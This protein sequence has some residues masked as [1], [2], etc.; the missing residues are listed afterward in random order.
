MDLSTVKSRIRSLVDDPD[1]SYATDAFLLPL[2]NQKY[3][4][5]YNRMLSTGAEFERRVIELFNVPAQTTNLSSYALTGQPLELMVQPLQ[6]EW[7]QAGLAPTN[8]RAASL[9]DKVED[10]IPGQLVDDWEWRAGVIYFTPSTLALDI[11]I[12]GDFLFAA[13]NTDTDVVA[14]S[15]NFGHA[16]AYGTAALVG[17]VRGNQAWAQAYTL[18][19]DNALDDIMQYLTRKDQAKIRRVGRMSGRRLPQLPKSP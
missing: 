9:V 19:Q 6:F 2:I 13:L 16:L 17:A 4:E 5:L 18:L 3:E 12:R 11:R 14:V 10:V 1:A 7:K 8:Y 15:K